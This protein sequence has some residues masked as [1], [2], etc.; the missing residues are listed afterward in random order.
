ME[1]K[2]EYVRGA[3]ASLYYE[4]WERGAGRD[5][6]EERIPLLMLHGNGED[7][8]IFKEMAERMSRDF[9]VILMDSRGHGFSRIY[10]REEKQGFTTGDMAGD[11][12]EIMD[13]LKVP[14][15]AIL[16]FSDGANIALETASRYP[17]RV[18]AVAAVSGNALPWGV[19]PGFFLQVQSQYPLYWLGEHL[20]RSGE[21][22]SKLRRQRQLTGLMAFCPRLTARRL[23]KIKCP[24][25]LLTG[26][27]DMIRPRHS[28]WMAEKIP[29]AEIVFVKGA[30]HFTMLKRP[31]AYAGYIR[32]WPMRAAEPGSGSRRKVRKHTLGNPVLPEKC[33]H[34][35]GFR[36][37]AG[38]ALL[39]APGA[40]AHADGSGLPL[41]ALADADGREALSQTALI[42]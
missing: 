34:V 17:G 11:V 29:G 28:L 1:Q 13:A 15:A 7:H 16:G 33:R 22:R 18:L 12:I 38:K 4:V 25:L 24:V 39:A 32:R 5:G 27:R 40:L 19:T 21:R 14:R 10:A 3:H 2:T 30:D 8:G 9:R 41:I 26:R 35:R 23:G 36:R 37:A 6:R 31:K 20:A 42:I